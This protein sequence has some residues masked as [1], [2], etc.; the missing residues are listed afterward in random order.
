MYIYICIYVYIFIYLFIYL[1]IYKYSLYIYTFVDI[2]EMWTRIANVYI[3]YIIYTHICIYYIYIFIHSTYTGSKLLPAVGHK[4]YIP[5]K[6]LCWEMCGNPPGGVV[7]NS[8][9]KPSIL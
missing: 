7:G 4:L 6:E 1:F 9:L 3:I 8:V 2:G 5:N